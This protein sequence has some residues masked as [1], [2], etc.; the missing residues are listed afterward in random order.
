MPNYDRPEVS[1]IDYGCG[2]GGHQRT[3]MKVVLNCVW[4]FYNYDPLKWNFIR[5][6]PRESRLSHMCVNVLPFVEPQCIDNVLKHMASKAK[7]LTLLS[8][9]GW[10][11]HVNDDKSIYKTDRNINW[12]NEKIAQYFNIGEAMINEQVVYFV[13]VRLSMH[14]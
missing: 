13:S 9:Y 7:Y 1:V 5:T 2:D 14:L 12:W 8:R 11:T 6:F 10:M 4:S 3:R